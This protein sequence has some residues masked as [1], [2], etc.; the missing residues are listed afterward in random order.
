MATKFVRG[1]KFGK[2]GFQLPHTA[3][4]VI[5]QNVSF[6]TDHIHRPFGKVPPSLRAI[7]NSSALHRLSAMTRVELCSL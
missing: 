3:N 4:S 5:R 2:E 1:L 6:E 7:S